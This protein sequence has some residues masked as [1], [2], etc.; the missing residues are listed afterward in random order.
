[1]ARRVFWHIGLP[2][3]GT[4]YLQDILWSNRDALRDAGLAMPGQGHREHL[5]AALEVQ[6]RDLR[7]RDPRAKG[8]W[9]RL[10]AEADR[11]DGDVLLTHE[12]FCGASREQAE[13]AAARL[14]PAEVHVIVTARHAAAMLAA[15][16][17]ELVKNGGEAD[18]AEVAARRSR[19]E[20]SWR[21]W[22]LHGVLERWE[23]VV[24]SERLHVL[25]VPGRDQP[26]DQHWHNLRT[27][28]GLPDEFQPPEGAANRSLGAVQVEL[29]RRVNEHLGDF[30][31]RSVDRGHWIRGYLAERHLVAQDGER[32]GLSD[33]L[34][35]DCRLRSERA[36]DLI[37]ERGLDVVGDPTSLLV[38]AELPPH[39]SVETVSDAEMLESATRLIAAMLGDLRKESEAGAASSAAGDEAPREKARRAIS[40]LRRGTRN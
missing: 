25:P 23:G 26:A 38:P 33:E 11:A 7:R 32:F 16:W 34:L 24:P 5:W 2:K 27:L 13:R 18:I 4:T 20:F 35:A 31:T 6:E 8:A 14:A 19:S 12:F 29:L 39:R 15:G 21:T 3:T 37:R 40:R 22:D 30:R 1:M 10:C 36:V 28:L 17:Q 9:E